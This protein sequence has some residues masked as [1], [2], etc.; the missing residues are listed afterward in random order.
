MNQKQRLA[1]RAQIY[2]QQDLASDHGPGRPPGP[3]GRRSAPRAIGHAA[4]MRR[5]RKG[6]P[7]LHKLALAGALTVTQ[8]A[9]AAGLLHRRDQQPPPPVTGH[10]RA[11]LAETNHAQQMELWFGP[12]RY[13]GSAFASDDE[14]RAIWCK[15][16]EQYIAWW[17]ECWA[18]RKYEAALPQRR[19]AFN[20][21]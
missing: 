17:G 19:E 15:H 12:D 4:L 13:K 20:A 5:L 2:H 18:W 7:E 14:R 8:A 9:I 6:Y 1:K 3:G 10:A 16:R 11:A 21:V